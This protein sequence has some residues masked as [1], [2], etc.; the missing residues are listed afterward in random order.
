LDV[1]Y[2]ETAKDTI[3]TR[4]SPQDIATQLPVILSRVAQGEEFDVTDQGQTVARIVPPT[5]PAAEPS[6]QPTWQ[7][8]FDEWMQEVDARAGRYPAGFCVSD[9]RDDIYDGRGV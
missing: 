2:A 6:T 5:A 8:Q 4:I 7:K 9:G 1:G 3:M